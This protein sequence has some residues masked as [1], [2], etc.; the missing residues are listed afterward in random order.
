M[1]A[2]DSNSSS[3]PARD[4]RYSAAAQPTSRKYSPAHMLNPSA[5]KVPNVTM[6]EI[7]AAAREMARSRVRSSP[8]LAARTRK[9]VR[10]ATT[11]TAR[12]SATPTIPF[13]IRMPR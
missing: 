2:S 9:Q 5:S 1:V 4:N 10:A 7:S 3:T 11:I 13:S 12:N 8:A 6:A